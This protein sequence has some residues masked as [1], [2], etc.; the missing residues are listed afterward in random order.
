MIFKG[1]RYSSSEVI[2]SVDA[3]G[4]SVRVLATRTIPAAPGAL[5]YIACEGDRLDTLANRFYAEPTR[6]WLI[7]D[8]NPEPLNP[9]ELL[10]PGRAIQVPRN[11]L[12]GE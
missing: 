5:E 9:F 6:Y 7:L 1:S 11:R 8:A 12:V 10:V 2:T 3:D 4:R